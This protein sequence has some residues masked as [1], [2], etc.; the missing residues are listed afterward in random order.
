[1]L[2]R[3][4]LLV[5]VLAACGHERPVVT[6]V[7]ASAPTEA[8]MAT[9]ATT[10]ATIAAK[11]SCQSDDDCV[12]VRQC[13]GFGIYARP[14][15]PQPPECPQPLTCAG[16]AESL[17]THLLCVRGGCVGLHAPP[18][19]APLESACQ[20]DDDCIVV[21][22]CCGPRIYSRRFTPP[23]EACAEVEC[24]TVRSSPP[25]RVVCRGGWCLGV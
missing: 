25:R 10:P 24:P 6:L 13:C 16:D 20:Y 18:S 2:R 15:A 22:R 5:A 11:A 14:A 8:P 12:V 21:P 7:V 19:P 9:P 23:V 4:L 17:P 1:M 3:T